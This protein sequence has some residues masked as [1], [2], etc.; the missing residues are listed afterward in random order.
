MTMMLRL[1]N[2]FLFLSKE[3]YET[4]EEKGLSHNLGLCIQK[5]IF[6]HIILGLTEITLVFHDYTG[7][8]TSKIGEG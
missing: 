5:L 7:F 2:F 1:Y 8:E 6:G 3:L 4:G